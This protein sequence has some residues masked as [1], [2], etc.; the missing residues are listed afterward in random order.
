MGEHAADDQDEVDLESSSLTPSA[1]CDGI[2]RS[3]GRGDCVV[4]GCGEGANLPA[5]GVNWSCVSSAFRPGWLDW[6][7]VWAAVGTY[8]AELLDE[9]FVLLRP[10][11]RSIGGQVVRSLRLDLFGGLLAVEWAEV[12]AVRH[13]FRA[14]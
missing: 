11:G 14:G 10:D 9:I 4:R 12:A 1:V 7:H 6:S 3:D 13:E 8:V 5:P 2:T